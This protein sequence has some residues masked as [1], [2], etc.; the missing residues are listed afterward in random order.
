MAR[1]GKGGPDRRG[2]RLRGERRPSVDPAG[3]RGAGGARRRR[4]PTAS[5]SASSAS[6]ASSP[7]CDQG[8]HRAAGGDEVTRFAGVGEERDREPWHRPGSG[9]A[10]R[11][12]GPGRTRPGSRAGRWPG[13]R[14]PRSRLA[15]K[16]SPS[17]VAPVAPPTRLAAR[18][19]TGPQGRPAEEECGPLARAQHLG[20]LVD[21]LAG[22]T[23]RRSVAG[24][25]RARVRWPTRTR[26][27][28]PAGPAWPRTRGG[29]G[30]R[31]GVGRVRPH[32]VGPGRHPI[33]A[34]DGAGDRSD[35]RLERGVKARVVRGV[36][37]HDVDHRCPG[38]PGVVQVGQPV[39]QSGAEVQQ[40]RGRSPGHP[41]VA[42]GG[43]GRHSL[44]ERQD[45][46]ASRARHR[47]RP[48]SA[49]P[50]SPGC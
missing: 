14:R 40:G 17:R 12:A 21:G 31:H 7:C 34:R 8:V 44:E 48:R 46:R 38:P 41:G 22:A 16:V 35:V 10:R 2:Q 24:P 11:P 26:T 30:G 29:R 18:E 15:G 23:R 6:G 33:P 4:A 5:A 25:G 43:T 39:A 49:S 37:A 27:S 13:S 28:R 32:V 20:H 47:A 45:R 36:V 19:A 1:S 50:R 3:G 9:A 42:V